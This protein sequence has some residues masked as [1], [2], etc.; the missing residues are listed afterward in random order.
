MTLTDFH[1]P[2]TPM[3]DSPTP[4]P[5][6]SAASILASIMFPTYKQ[7]KSAIGLQSMLHFSCLSTQ[8]NPMPKSRGYEWDS[9]NSGGWH[10]K[11]QTCCD[12]HHTRFRWHAKFT[13]QGRDALLLWMQIGW[14][15]TA[16]IS[17]SSQNSQLKRRLTRYTDVCPLGNVSANKLYGRE[18]I[19]GLRK[20]EHLTPAGGTRITC[21]KAKMLW[22]CEHKMYKCSSPR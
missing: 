12:N 11:L 6:D 18:Q 13:P 17:G 15:A 8:V 20:F 2:S 5:Q 16:N 1:H 10:L 4:P 22:C 19:L 14:G 3:E 7:I 9:G 21:D